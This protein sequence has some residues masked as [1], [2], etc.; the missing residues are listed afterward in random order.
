[1][2]VL[3]RVSQ[4]HLVRNAVFVGWTYATSEFT[5]QT[6]LGENYD[7]TKMQHLA[8]WGLCFNGPGNFVWYKFLDRVFPGKTLKI[9]LKKMVL[10]KLTMSPIWYGGFFI[11]LSILERRPDIFAE[12]KQKIVPTYIAGCAFWI[13]A[14]TI[15]FMFVPNVYRV[16]YV[17]TAAFIWA[18]F[19]CFMKR[20]DEV[21]LRP[22]T[23]AYSS[24]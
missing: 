24:E 1:M 10:E 7:V 13:P 18:N 19:L 2:N 23:V 3:R 21:P 22:Q 11:V 9:A 8:I 17:G 4:S 6:I 5:Q 20:Q 14:Q 12:A 16:V 15:N